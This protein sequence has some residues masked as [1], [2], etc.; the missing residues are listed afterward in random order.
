MSKKRKYDFYEPK[1]LARR[2]AAVCTPRRLY[3][4]ERD[5]TCSV[6]CLR[7]MLSGFLDTVPTE[8]DLVEGW[9]L[10]PQPYFSKDIKALGMLE[11]Y[12]VIYGCDQ[13]DRD[14]DQ[15][16]DCLGQG[17]YV[18]VESMYNYAHWFVLLGYYPL[19]GEDTEASRL[20]VYD[21]YYHET[22]LLNTDE[23]MAMWLDGNHGQNGVE[24]DFIALRQRR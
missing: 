13:P 9:K 18:M 10:T 23:F 16:L 21:P 11:D 8:E 4:Q 17:W 3:R 22:R 20:L 14:F 15:V 5:W 12:E 24:K 7:S 19:E 2:E 1:Q 6:A